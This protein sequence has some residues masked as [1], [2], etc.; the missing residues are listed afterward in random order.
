MATARIVDSGGRVIIPSETLLDYR[1]LSNSQGILSASILTMLANP[2]DTNTIVITNGTTTR[3]YSATSGGDVAYAIG[4]DKETTMA[5]FAAAVT[6]DGS[7]AWYAYVCTGLTS[8][9]ATVVVIIARATALAGSKIYGTWTTPA[10]VKIVDYTGLRDYIYK[11]LSNMPASL[12]SLSNFGFD[13]IAALLL[14]GETHYVRDTAGLAYTWSAESASWIPT[15]NIATIASNF[16]IVTDTYTILFTD[17]VIVC[18]KGTA[19][20]VTLPPATGS[21]TEKRIKN[22]GIGTVTLEGDSNDTIDG[23]LNQPIVTW[24]DLVV[25]DYATNKWAIL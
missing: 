5:N 20:I 4:V 7:G 13:R 14:I 21:G 2:V 22:V 6:A 15:V 24:D 1:Q 12:P 10:N 8:I 17:G 3:T 25:K 18:N 16:K 9:A 11:T 23:E 19:F